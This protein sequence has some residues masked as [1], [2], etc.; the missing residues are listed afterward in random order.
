VKVELTTQSLPTESDFHTPYFD[1][2]EKAILAN[3]PKAIVVPYI[4]PG[5]TDNH[6]FR[7]K[8]VVSYGIIPMLIS[9]EDLEGLHGKNER[10]LLTELQ[11]GENILYD[12]VTS[13]QGL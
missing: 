8:G 13:L 9:M 6:F 7:A 3:D 4:S 11:R 1:T 10:I 12:L 2:L 5:A